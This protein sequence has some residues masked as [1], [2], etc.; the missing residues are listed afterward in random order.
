MCAR[1]LYLSFACY[2]ADFACVCSP[3]SCPLFDTAR[4][5]RGWEVRRACVYVGARSQGAARAHCLP[6]TSASPCIRSSPVHPIFPTH[7]SPR[8]YIDGRLTSMSVSTVRLCTHPDP[9]ACACA[10]Y[11]S[12][13]RQASLR[14]M[15]E[16]ITTSGQGPDVAGG[17]GADAGASREGGRDGGGVMSLFH[18][19]A[20]PGAAPAAVS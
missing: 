13:P 9:H 7:D 16:S 18:V 1:S 11:C 20:S 10:C 14:M 17:A 2:A 8:S 12:I 6:F 3:E 19:C 5:V 15:A 4:W